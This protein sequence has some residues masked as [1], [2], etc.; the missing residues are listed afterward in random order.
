M[1]LSKVT[2][3]G[4]RNVIKS[5]RKGVPETSEKIKLVF[6]SVMGYL[7]WLLILRSLQGC[8]E[9]KQQDLAVSAEK[10]V[11]AGP[12][13]TEIFCATRDGPKP[14]YNVTV[15]PWFPAHTRIWVSSLLSLLRAHSPACDP[16]RSFLQDPS[17]HE[18]TYQK[19]EADTSTRKRALKSPAALQLTVHYRAVKT[20]Q[21]GDGADCLHSH[22]EGSKLKKVMIQTLCKHFGGPTD[23]MAVNDNRSREAL[24]WIYG[25]LLEP[26][27]R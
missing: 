18:E 20:Q 15:F 3:A 26:W 25:G 24:H 9:D 19:D 12:D 5:C 21:S 14:S 22:K 11:S 23:F 17:K 10:E 27:D 6:L 13:T 4:T 7:L 1:T 16:S 2:T 8:L